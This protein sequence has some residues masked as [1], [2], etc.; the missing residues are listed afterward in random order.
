[1]GIVSDRVYN[2]AEQK[3]IPLAVHFDLTYRCNLH[4]IHCYL[5]EKDRYPS[6]E[7]KEE[8]KKNNRSELSTE[9]V[10]DTLDQLKEAGTLFIT[11]SGGEIFLRSDILDIVEYAREKRFSVSLM[12]TG[13]VNFSPKVAK[14]LASLGL[15][16]VDISV[17]SSQ[18]ETH[19]SITQKPGSFQKT[20]NSISHLRKRGIKVTLKCP[21]MKN[22]S[23]SYKG[24]VD[25]AD[26]YGTDYVIDPSITLGKDGNQ[27]QAELRL[28]EQE[29]LKY[30]S[31]SNRI[32]AKEEESDSEDISAPICEDFDS[33]YPCGASHS[34]CY[35]SPY[36]EVQPCIEITMDCGNI[37]EENF[38]KVWK[39]S[40]KMNKVRK[41]ERENLEHCDDCPHPKYCH[42]CIGQSYL[43]H[44]SLRAPSDENCK[45]M[46][47]QAQLTE[48]VN[49]NEQREVQSI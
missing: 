41:V 20:I 26:T 4:C 45:H 10:F 46:K 5:P 14:T 29:L 19:D 28:S 16:A 15:Q 25:L 6:Q 2:R 34:S 39:N 38:E 1:M 17:Y 40:N 32:N 22:N 44:G 42:R 11:F 43:E 48:E 8:L 33:S 3:T 47:L 9:E 13:T 37:R 36:G 31:F 30:Y 12:T 27:R 49:N 23:D 7:Y 18:P 24:I 35:I 21:L